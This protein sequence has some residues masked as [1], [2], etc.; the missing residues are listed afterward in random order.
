MTHALPLFFTVAAR[1]VILLGTGEAADAKRRILERAGATIVGEEADARLAIVAI[2]D[3]G[4]ALAAVARLKVRGVL[5][6]AVDRPALCDFILP[7]MIDR[8]PVLIA[9]ST[10]GASAAL[11]ATLRQRLEALIP[12]TLGTL[13]EALRQA[14]AAIHAKFPEPVARRRALSDAL[15]A[16]APL[17]VLAGGD[18]NAWLE[19][20]GG[21]ASELVR[22]ALRSPDPDELTLREARWLA[23]AD[24]L[25]HR[26]DVPPAILARARADAARIACDAPPADPGAGFSI[27]LEM[28]A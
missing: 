13:A 18:V 5:V 10:G 1:P 6:N 16:G 15:G 19:A 11:A 23:Q 7:A 27:D 20:A 28:A 12:A 4:E 22:I 9:I 2:D 21:S 24:R 14:R 3:P 8:A 17:D 25:F 26:D